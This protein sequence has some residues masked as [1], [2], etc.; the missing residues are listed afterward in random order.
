MKKNNMKTRIVAGI[1]SAITIFSV[2]TIAVTSASAAQTT[3]S[4]GTT[5]T[6]DNCVKLDKDLTT[7]KKVTS[8]LLFK[9]LD[10][11]TPW[12][13]FVTPVMGSL[14]DAFAVNYDPT[15]Q[16]LDDISDKLDKLSAKLDAAETSLK[17]AFTDDLGIQSFYSALV[18]FKADTTGFQRKISEALKNDRLSNADKMAKIASLTGKESEWP[19]RFEKDFDA[20]N[21]YFQKPA[22][23]KEGNIFTLTYNYFTNEVML[24]GEA[25]DK[26]KP[27]CDFVMATY[28]AG[29]SAIMESL[30]A[31][32]YVNCLSAQTKATIDKDYMAQICTKPDEIT[33]E[34]SHIN[35]YL[36]TDKTSEDI[37]GFRDADGNF[38][39]CADYELSG[40]YYACPGED[41]GLL[42]DRGVP[43]GGVELTPIYQYAPSTFMGLYQKTFDMSRAILVDNGHANTALKNALTVLN[44]KSYT[45]ADGKYCVGMGS[46]TAAWFNDTL[47]ANAI[48][49]DQVK[50]L[51]ADA[52][53]KG[54]TLRELLKQNG[55]NTSRLPKNANLVTQSA[56]DESV[57]RASVVV[58]Y[59]YQKAF[60]KGI[61]IDSAA[62]DEQ[63]IQLLDCGKNFWTSS[64]WNYMLAGNA[65]VFKAA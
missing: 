24:S 14:I 15:V 65:C 48:N 36:V 52:R 50:R 45:K 23:T 61:N 1:L 35:Q 64:N 18:N 21:N 62:P 42:P 12:G 51:A 10:E 29:C 55:F 39:L 7:A 59:N 44:H 56:W 4:A 19:A 30:S 25:L 26:A 5:I 28:S 9:A 32:L 40:K 2:G 53:S 3:V 60:Y 37:I 33:A 57:D 20:L 17:A 43:A 16:K 8:S 41:C 38:Y 11:C 63:T 34:I 47:G 31:Q 46:L 54:I 13:K 27:I 49:A 6:N 22:M 58:G